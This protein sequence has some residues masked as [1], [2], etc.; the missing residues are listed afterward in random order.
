MITVL[1]LLFFCLFLIGLVTRVSADTY[2][3]TEEGH[4]VVYA[5]PYYAFPVSDEDFKYYEAHFVSI[6]C[7][8]RM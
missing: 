2:E 3:T 5:H 4:I 6:H 7:R 1:R 8:L